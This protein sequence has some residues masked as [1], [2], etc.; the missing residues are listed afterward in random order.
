MLIPFA[1][2][3]VKYDLHFFDVIPGSLERFFALLGDFD[4]FL[5]LYLGYF[6]GTFWGANY[7]AHALFGKFFLAN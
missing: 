2:I 7:L 6:D 3:G 1:D 5:L 4:F